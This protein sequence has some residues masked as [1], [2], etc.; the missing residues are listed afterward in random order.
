MGIFN[1]FKFFKE[2]FGDKIYRINRSVKG[3][4][5]IDVDNLMIDMNGIFHTSAQKIFKYGSCKPPPHLPLIVVEDNQRNQQKVFKDVCES[6]ET[7]LLTVNP[8]KR[9]ILCVDGAAPLAKQL[10]QSKRRYVSSLTRS[11]DDLSFDSNCISPGTKFMD[12]LNKYVDWFIRS[13]LSEDPLW[14]NLEVIFSSDKVEA[15]GEHKLQSYVRKFGK[16]NETFMIHGL[17]S[18]L[19]M[20]SL[21]SHCSQFYVLR[22]D[23]FDRTNNFLLLDMPKIRPQIISLMKWECEVLDYD[24]KPIYKFNENWAINDFVFLCFMVGNDFLHHVPALEIVEGGI[25]VIIDCCKKVGATNG[26]ITRYDNGKVIFSPKCLAKFFESIS[27]FEQEL[28]ERKM[29]HRRLYFPDEILISSVRINDK[30]KAYD[31]DIDQYRGIYCAVHFKK[32]SE[33]DMFPICHEYL[34]GLQWVLHYYTTGVADWNWIFPYHYTPPAKV[35]AASISTYEPKVFRRNKPMLPFQQLLYILPVKSSKLLPAPLSS[36]M[37]IFKA[38]MMKDIPIDLSGK[39]YEY[40]GVVLMPFLDV[41]LI[42][43]IY[44]KYY[45][46]VSEVDKKR[47]YLGKTY[48]FKYSPLAN[49][50]FKSYYG[51]FN[52]KV[53]QSSIEI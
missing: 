23:T 50:I 22:D 51:N 8:N 37:E 19:I 25:D 27:D 46:E 20:L 18:D 47:N 10:Q 28:L 31:V 44:K 21:I 29:V 41:K 38:E 6:I 5:Y 7:I 33:E 15:E 30:T 12:H 40:Q 43:K 52:S 36:Q 11:D 24:E 14:Q 53:V 17:D 45:D 13:K 3:E 39:K 1:F 16:S 35:L 32:T 49:K 42:Q 9:L 34:D 48:A 4:V 2:R 26:H